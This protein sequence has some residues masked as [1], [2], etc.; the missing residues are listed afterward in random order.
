MRKKY[1]FILPVLFL[2]IGLFAQPPETI[3]SGDLIV[4]GYYNNIPAASDGPFPIGFNFTFFGNTYSQFYVSANGLVMFT[5]PAASY[6]ASVT[7]PSSAA[8][9]NYIAPFWDDLVIDGSGQIL[10]KTIGASPNRKLIIQFKNMGFYPFPVFMGSF[11]VIMYETS[12]V[13]QVQYRI[14]VDETSAKAHGQ[15]AT[16]GIENSDGSAGFLHAFHDGNAVT[17]N[18]AISFTPSGATYTI[19]SNASYEGIFLTTNLSLPEAG[20]PSLISPAGNAVTGT[21]QTFVW[22]GVPNVETYSLL[23]SVNSDLADAVTYNAGTNLSYE[24]TGLIADATYYWSVFPQNATG[25]TW[26]EIKKFTTS[27][28]PPLIPVSQS[29]W[30]EQ[31]K[32]TIIKLYY[33]G[34]DASAKTADITALPGQGQLYQSNAGSTGSLIST[35]PATVTDPDMKVIY[36]ASGNTGNGAGNFSFKIHDDTGDSPEGLITVNVNPPGVP[37]VLV[38]AKS[39]NIEIQFDRPMA[40]PVGKEGQFTATVNGTP[41]SVSSANL[42]PGDINTI[43]LT[44]SSPLTGSETVLVSYTQGDIASEEGGYLLTFTDHPVTKIAQMVSFPVLPEKKYGDPPFSILASSPSGLGFTYGS[45]NLRVATILTRTVTIRGAGKSEITAFQSGNATYAP[46]RFTRLLNVI[47]G[48]QTITFNPLPSKTYGDSDFNPGAASSSGLTVTYTSDNNSV[49]TVTGGFIH[50]NGAGS[51]VI[52]ASQ[53]GNAN[54]NPAADVQQILTVN[55]ASQSI[56]FGAIPAKTFGDPEFNPGATASSGLAVTYSSSEPGI[57]NVVNNMIYITG[58]GSAIITASQAGDANYSPAADVQQAITV[59]KAGQV[60]T[61]GPLPAVTYGD[62][63]TDPGAVSSSGLTIIYSSNNVNV[64]T[65]LNGMIHITGAGNAV[66]TA[67]QPGNANFEPAADVQQPL[68]VNKADQIITFNPIVAKTYGDPDFDPQASSDSGLGITYSSQNTNV[69]ETDGNMIHITSAGNT[70]ITASQPGNTNYNPAPDVQQTL[71]VNKADLTFA[72]D[73]KSRPYLQANPSFTYTIA[74]FVNSD[75]QSVLDVLPVIQTN[76][77]Q[78]SDAGDYTITFQGG[79]DDNY[80]YVFVNGTLTITK[81]SQTITF[82]DIPEKIRVTEAYTLAASSSSGLNVLFESMDTRLAVITGNQF[83]GLAGG[84]VQVR[85]FQSGN[86]NYLASEIFADVVI[87]ST[88]KDI[89]HLFT[90]NN[91]GINDLWEIPEID[92]YGRCDV[93]VFNR[94]GKMVYSSTSYNNDWDGNSNGSELP[95]AAYYFIIS[96]ENSGTITGTVN[97][98]R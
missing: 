61:F 97:I 42:K 27:S 76:A 9:N 22:S 30:L 75:D 64:A 26:C 34:G 58:A 38:A 95:E 24:I 47:K 46:A 72:A 40:D 88:H 74:G 56:T 15:N 83:T 39:S 77:T 60:I 28:T 89:L 82:T 37:S 1:L 81:I 10:Y 12:N 54:Y 59:N 45:S 96:T 6:P 90:P 62:S 20:K 18:Q 63:D 5:D 19:N 87:S 66:I 31:N 53:A 70:I 17:T 11:S 23:I 13:V 14:I 44:L 57:A 36:L 48:D 65:I 4:K 85:A 92:T 7:I 94:W 73:N 84:T 41:V 93:K 2:S 43:E 78:N 67:S 32:D 91:D 55:K 68:T 71:N 98:V 16:I 3:Y 49:A 50:I 80:N 51:A 79:S 21:D 35:A 52:T 8:P 69:A 33:N 25:I 86:T 29:L